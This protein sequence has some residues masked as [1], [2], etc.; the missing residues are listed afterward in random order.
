VFRGTSWLV[1][2]A[3]AYSMSFILKNSFIM[4]APVKNIFE[5]HLTNKY[6]LA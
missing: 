1:T 4:P 2:N 3:L 5:L 6:E